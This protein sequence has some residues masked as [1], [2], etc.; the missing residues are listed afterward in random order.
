MARPAGGPLGISRFLRCAAK[1]NSGAPQRAIKQIDAP[2]AGGSTRRAAWSSRL[3]LG[4]AAHPPSAPDGPPGWNDAAARQPEEV[5]SF[6]QT[7]ERAVEALN[8]ANERLSEQ[9]RLVEENRHQEEMVADEHG[10]QEK[11]L[12]LPV[13]PELLCWL[14]ETPGLTRFPTSSDGAALH[15]VQSDP[16]VGKAF[17]SAVGSLVISGL[18]RLDGVELNTLE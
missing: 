6:M 4:L 2:R 8:N 10:H 13:L 9:A 11:M 18:R 7:T 16:V 3:L 17:E 12:M 5:Y 1:A 14:L 15:D